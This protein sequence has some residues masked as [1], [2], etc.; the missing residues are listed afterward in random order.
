ME[1]VYI[2]IIGNFCVAMINI[3]TCHRI[4]KTQETQLEIQRE[5]YRQIGRMSL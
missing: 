2:G 3:Y 5:L 4:S 1:V